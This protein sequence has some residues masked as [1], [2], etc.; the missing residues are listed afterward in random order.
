MMGS[1][2]VARRT[3]RRTVDASTAAARQQPSDLRRD[4]TLGLGTDAP[5][6]SSR[7]RWTD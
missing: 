7:V 1:R 5:R 6:P 4:Q 3:S 2:R